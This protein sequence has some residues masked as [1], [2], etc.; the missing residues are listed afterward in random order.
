MGAMAL[1]GVS[2]STGEPQTLTAFCASCPEPAEV[3]RLLQDLGFHLAF[4]LPADKANAS[5]SDY[6]PPLAAQY[7]F[8]DEIG[9]SV[10]YLAGVDAACLADDKD[11]PEEPVR[12]RY[13]PHASR[14]W[15]IAGGR[16]LVVWRVRDALA[17]RWN[18][19]WLEL[20]VVEPVEEAA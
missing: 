15:L 8:E 12:Y 13:P 9:T 11:D 14:F 18:L 4:F 10:A 7:H 17:V 19:R 1:T 6:L 2:R 20:N 3:E 16:E 5:M